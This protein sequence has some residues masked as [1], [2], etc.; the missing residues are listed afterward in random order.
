MD[1]RI[2]SGHDGLYSAASISNFK[3]PNRHCER[4]RSNP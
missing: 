3:Q 4:K 1:A 2:K